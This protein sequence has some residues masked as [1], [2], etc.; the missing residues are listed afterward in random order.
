M[1]HYH[2]WGKTVEN[3]LI[4]IERAVVD[5]GRKGPFKDE[6]LE[7]IT[8]VIGCATI[9]PQLPKEWTSIYLKD[10]GMVERQVYF[11]A[12]LHRTNYYPGYL[13][14]CNEKPEYYYISGQIGTNVTHKKPWDQYKQ[15]LEL[16]EIQ[17]DATQG[18]I[19]LLK[20]YITCA[21]EEKLL[22]Y[23]RL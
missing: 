12:K 19:S 3:L 6:D 9:L 11:A 21:D 17:Y 13:L 16:D 7:K 8:R 14:Y 2:R 15:E 22:K 4:R 1:I 5:D 23:A 20:N 18:E 10:I